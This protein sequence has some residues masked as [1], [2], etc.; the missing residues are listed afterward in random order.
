[1]ERENEDAQQQGGW[2]IRVA[3]GALF[4]RSGWPGWGHRVLEKNYLCGHGQLNQLDC[5]SQFKDSII[6]FQHVELL[7]EL[8]SMKIFFQLGA[9][10]HATCQRMKEAHTYICLEHY[11]VDTL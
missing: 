2:N 1:M 4:G 7:A 11:A 8:A 3:M 5:K 6:I 9:L 10:A